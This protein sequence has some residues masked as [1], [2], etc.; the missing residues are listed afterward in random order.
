MPTYNNIVLAL[1]L[2]QEADQVIERGKTLMQHNECRITLLHVVEPVVTESSYDL[3][4]SL[5]ADYDD[6]LRAQAK[7]FLRHKR[8]AFD[9]KDAELRV[10]SGSI[11]SEIL[12]V[13][14]DCGADLVVVGTHG[15]HGVSLLLGSTANSVLHGTPCDV[16]AVRIQPASS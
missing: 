1:D 15:R 7:D 2:S 6:T 9:L 3:I 12:R 13:A 11:K 4:T 14:E 8:D 5:P 10:E 16:L